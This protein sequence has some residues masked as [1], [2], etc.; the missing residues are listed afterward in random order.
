MKSPYLP[1]IRNGLEITFQFCIPTHNKYI[2]GDKTKMRKIPVAQPNFIGN[3]RD[4][5]LDCIDTTWISSAGKYIQE[6]ENEFAKFCETNHALSCCNGTV[7]LHLA[8]MALGISA[9]DEIIIPALT[10]IATS[11][12]VK[13]V[14]AKPVFVDIDPN[15]WNIDPSKIE[16]KITEKTR[17]I[18][19]V[20]LYGNPADMDAIMAIAH[21]HKLYVIEDAAEAH[22]ALYKGKKAG[23]IGDIGTFSFFGN[24]LITTGEGG[25]VTTNNSDLNDSMRLL[26]GQGVDPHKRYWH[27]IIG[28][29]YRMTNIEAAIGLAQLE[30]IDT[31][32][33]LRE[34]IMKQY[35]QYLA[36]VDNHITFQSIQAESRPI[37]WMVSL[38]FKDSVNLSRDTIIEKLQ[39]AG[40]ETRP[41]FYVINDMPPYK[42]NEIFPCASKIAM[43][44]INLPTYGSMTEEDVKYVCDALIEIIKSGT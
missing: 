33:R 16:E 39:D 26:K 5:V 42:N 19:V 44:G 21:K 23:S 18:I 40:I 10:Y 34:T 37:Y 17:A 20:H 22:G 43:R 2:Q 24:K 36:S 32:I 15:T 7:A 38:T 8:L 3:E 41:V 12:A 9:G 31:H 6:F 35:N 13:Y 25:M 11:N 27:S 4:Y 29:N 14:N 1:Q 30:K 28:Y